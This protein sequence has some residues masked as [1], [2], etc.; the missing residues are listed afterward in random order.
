MGFAPYKFRF[1]GKFSDFKKEAEEIL[2]PPEAFDG[3]RFDYTRL[4]S[5]NF[6][7]GHGW[8]IGSQQQPPNYTLNVNWAKEDGSVKKKKKK[9]K[10]EGK[11]GGKGKKKKKKKK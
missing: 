4:V 10:K 1:P 5:S 6:A 8:V 2:H 11:K 7:V 3:I 9:K